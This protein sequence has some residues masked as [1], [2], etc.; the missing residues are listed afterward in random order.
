VLLAQ[1]FQSVVALLLQEQLMET[2][3]LQ[4]VGAR[5][6]THLVSQVALLHLLVTQLTL[7]FNTLMLFVQLRIKNGNT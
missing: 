5:I 3:V 4:A 6:L 7:Q 2:R 1:V